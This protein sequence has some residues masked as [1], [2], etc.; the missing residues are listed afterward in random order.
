MASTRPIPHELPLALQQQALLDLGARCRNSAL[1]YVIFWLVLTMVHGMAE[2]HTVLVVLVALLLLGLAIA[3]IIF[4]DHL[5]TLIEHHYKRSL[6]GFRALV[7]VH[8]FVWGCLCAM[9]QHWAPARSMHTYM[10]IVGA[11]LLQGGL[12]SMAFDRVLRTAFPMSGLTPVV[13][14]SLLA[15]NQEGFVV[16][17]LCTVFLA[18][19]VMTSRVVGGDYW[20]AQFARLTAEERAEQ[21]ELISQTDALTQVPNRRFFNLTIEL[22]WAR[23]RRDRRPLSVAMVDLDFFKKVNDTY[24]HPFGD[25]VLTASAAALKNALLRPPDMVA[26]FGGEE[27]VLLMPNTDLEGARVVAERMNQAVRDIRLS[28]GDVP[29]PVTCSIGIASLMPGVGG[30]MQQDIDNLL[31]SADLGL[32]EAKHAG[33][34]RVC[35][36]ED[37]PRPL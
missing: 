17:V 29:V 14:F 4:I 21:L 15:W 1:T 35:S 32:Y 19:Q 3:R 8:I 11:T 13:V 30:N 23:A 22:E 26:R 28:S 25:V 24:G 20:N 2:S 5:P 9:S 31:Q 6:L 37:A 10:I 27:F 33:R 36:K 7:L 12:V 34:D 18:Y 16:A